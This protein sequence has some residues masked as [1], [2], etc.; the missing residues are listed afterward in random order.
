[1]TQDSHTFHVAIEE[2]ISYIMS[3]FYDTLDADIH[4]VTEIK[5][6]TS[7]LAT[8]LSSVLSHCDEQVV[9]HSDIKDTEESSHKIV[10]DII[11]QLIESLR[12]S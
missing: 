3:L 7:F 9:S 6:T 4:S 12:M 2:I 1:M 5:S 10:N 8:T 11:Y